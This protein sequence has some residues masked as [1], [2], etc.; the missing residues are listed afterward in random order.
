MKGAN[1]GNGLEEAVCKHVE[2][3]VPFPPPITS[4][5]GLVP[6]WASHSEPSSSFPPPGPRSLA[7]LAGLG[8]ALLPGLHSLPTRRQLPAGGGGTPRFPG[9][10]ACAALV[11][12]VVGP[13]AP[14]F[15]RF[16]LFLLVCRFS[17]LQ[18]LWKKKMPLHLSLPG[19]TASSV[20][21]PT[22]GVS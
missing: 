13:F 11:V 4:A 5:Q 9:R 17:K 6:T 22:V 12:R 8:T 3:L 19:S 1:C 16:S 21:S 15:P 14:P 2:G 10:E 20:E 18:I 7:V